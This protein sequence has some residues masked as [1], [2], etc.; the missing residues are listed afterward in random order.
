L[1][2][3]NVFTVDDTIIKITVYNKNKIIIEAI[4]NAKYETYIKQYIW[5]LSD[6]KGPKYIKTVWYDNNGIQHQKSLHQLIIEISGQIVP[7]GY[8]IDHKDGNSLNCLDD[9]LRVCTQSQN[10]QNIKKYN[11]NKSGYKGVS[12]HKASNK[13]V[14]Q[15]TINKSHKYL[16]AFPTKEDAARAYNVA[17]I[18]HFGEYAVLNDI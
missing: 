13:W 10:R 14:A 9:N 6:T 8:E 3:H 11:N 1:K 16:G 5:R 12:W 4:S 18:I 17:A 15:I 7:D 2:I